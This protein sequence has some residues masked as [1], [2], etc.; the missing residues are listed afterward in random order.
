[1]VRASEATEVMIQPWASSRAF[2]FAG[3]MVSGV[4]GRDWIIVIHLVMLRP[5]CRSTLD[6]PD[7]SSLLL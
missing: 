4:Q 1:M 5:L 2:T 7:E 6:S 3:W